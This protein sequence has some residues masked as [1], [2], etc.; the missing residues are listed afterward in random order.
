MK[1]TQ[2]I[3]SNLV[4]SLIILFLVIV[5]VTLL[6]IYF[7][8]I[9]KPDSSSPGPVYK[10][11]SKPIPTYFIDPSELGFITQ[12]TTNGVD[13]PK[14][15]FSIYL[16]EKTCENADNSTPY[17]LESV[18]SKWIYD[19]NNETTIERTI[20]NKNNAYSQ[21]ELSALGKT[22]KPDTYLVNQIIFLY[23]KNN[24]NLSRK[25]PMIIKP[26]VLTTYGNYQKLYK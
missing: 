20:L 12:H 10:N 25:I 8:V 15:F 11:A 6:P 7:L 2:F 9:N 13:E 3:K 14:W 26:M 22:N 24:I 4:F 21:E 18:Q 19:K 23:D 1:F 17:T 16:S 5:P